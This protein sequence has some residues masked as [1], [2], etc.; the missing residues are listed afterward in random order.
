M[1]VTNLAIVEKA[2]VEFSP[3]LNVITGETGSGKSVLMGALRLAMGARADSS[4][5]RDGADEARVEAVFAL[6]GD[7]LGRVDAVLGD[8]GLDACE[9]GTLVIRRQIGADGKGRIWINGSAGTLSQ[10]R[11]LQPVLVDI[12]GPGDNR[13]ALDGSFQRSAVDGFGRTAALTKAKSAYAAAWEKFVRTGASLKELKA[14]SGESVADELDMLRFQ[15]AEIEDAALTEDDENIAE[16]HAAAAH[17]GE[18]LEE[19][20]A[21]TEALGGD[22]GVSAILASVSARLGRLS[23]FCREADA[24]RQ[25]ADEIAVRA[26][27]LS[28]SVADVASKTDTGE[29]SLEE[30]DRRL[31]LVNRLRRKYAAD[32]SGILE[33]VEAKRRRVDELE[34]SGER[35][36]ELEKELAAA[37]AAVESA[38][39]A[40][41][42]ERER[43]GAKMAKAVTAGLRGLG[44]LNAGFDVSVETAAASA[45][46]CDRVA[47]MFAPNPGEAARPLADIASSGETAR[48]MLALKEVLASADP[49]D[50]LVFDEIDANIGGEVGRAVGEK[51]RSAA[52]H[53]QV[54]AI[55]HLPQSAVYGDR[56]LVVGKSVEK[57]R[58]KSW[59][60]RAEGENRTSEIARM[61]G[62]EE[63][64]SV[65]RKHAEELLQLSR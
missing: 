26:E 31:T 21:V 45:D 6:A 18:I 47:F 63:L 36:A 11:R 65:V 56:H 62:G 14:L 46:G 64:T 5:V 12:H 39:A 55:T 9:D 40:L 35:L 61:L 24:W 7:L 2:E 16:R 30:L 15:I 57:G 52:A 19:A 59:I 43:A 60:L 3:A 38:G 34:N 44:F 20:N 4:V 1:T 23:R 37:A 25:E 17:A 41:R 42:A 53:H 54:I 58:T 22:D 8:S 33:L 27:E 48:V 29:E 49:V 28:R 51:M 13:S 50:V 32:V 10:L